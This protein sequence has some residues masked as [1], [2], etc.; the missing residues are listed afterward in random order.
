MNRVK[1]LLKRYFRTLLTFLV[2][3]FLIVFVFASGL[4]EVRWDSVLVA[5]LALPVWELFLGFRMDRAAIKAEKKRLAREAQE[6]SEMGEQAWRE[7]EEQRRQR[8]KESDR[9][10]NRQL[11]AGLLIDAAACCVYAYFYGAAH[12]GGWRW[13]KEGAP[14]MGAFLLLFLVPA[15][16]VG[17]I[18]VRAREKKLRLLEAFIIWPFFFL[19]F[20]PLLIG[21]GEKYL[22]GGMFL[23]LG[24]EFALLGVGYMRQVQ[25]KW[26]A[27]FAP[28][29]ARV[30]GN[31]RSRVRSRDRRPGY[32]LTYQPVVEYYAG[33]EIRR[34]TC[35][36]GQPRPLQ[37]GMPCEILYDPGCPENFRFT[38]ARNSFTERFGGLCAVG[39]GLF[40]MAAGVC[41]G[42]LW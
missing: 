35:S 34:V 27:C 9:R 17:S 2:W 42:F 5:C 4:E 14:V 1:G 6:R 10:W 3:L 24:Y 13:L 25:K 22:A 11:R 26:A 21:W 7:R 28:A 8:R 19:P 39:F 30:V 37:E 32:L 15:V 38:D 33:G 12:G 41:V 18:P 40:F 20:A 29:T 36:D 16:W 31:V 23:L